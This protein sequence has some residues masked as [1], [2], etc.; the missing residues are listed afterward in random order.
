VLYVKVMAYVYVYIYIYMS[1]NT[2]YCAGAFR[3]NCLG[4]NVIAV[5]VDSSIHS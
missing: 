4:L 1:W 5:N 3:I 2:E